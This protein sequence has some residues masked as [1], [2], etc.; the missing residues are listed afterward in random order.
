MKMKQIGHNE[1]LSDR[2]ISKSTTKAVRW[3]PAAAGNT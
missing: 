2:E 3:K 1:E